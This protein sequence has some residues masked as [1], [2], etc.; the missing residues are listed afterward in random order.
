MHQEHA[1]GGFDMEPEIILIP[2]DNGVEQEFEVIMKFEVDGTGAKYVLVVPVEIEDEDDEVY[3]FR[4]EENPCRQG[5]D[6][7]LHVIEDES[8][9]EL[10]EEVFNQ[11]MEDF[12]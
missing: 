6:I 11:L 10:V 12:E 4:Y 1:R 9:W 5:G 2:D 8:E 3:A 7:I